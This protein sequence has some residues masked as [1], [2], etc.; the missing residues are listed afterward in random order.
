V[1]QVGHLPETYDYIQSKTV[2]TKRAAKS[3]P[4]GVLVLE[5]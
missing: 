2:L 1:H 5:F 4:I 3:T